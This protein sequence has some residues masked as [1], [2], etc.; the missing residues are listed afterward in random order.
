MRI[1]IVAVGLILLI[2]IGVIVSSLLSSGDK[3]Q[4]QRLIEVTQKQS[5]IIRITNLA[6]KDIKDSN[7]RI[8][9][10]NTRIS[11]QNALVQTKKLLA[12]RGIKDKAL[13]KQLGLGKNTKT[14]TAFG[15]AADNNRFDET[16]LAILNQQLTDY[17]KLLKTAY[18]GGTNS[19]KTALLAAYNDTKL[20]VAKPA[21]EETTPTA[22]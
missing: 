3:A 6:N 13:N 12:K 4:N 2:I 18:D 11:T 17:Q 20:L 5:E 9:A 7:T 15:E 19:E 22:Q 16:F 8:L 14:D 10:T 21:T 1:L